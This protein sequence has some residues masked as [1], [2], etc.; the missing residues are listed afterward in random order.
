MQKHKKEDIS[1][2]SQTSYI[3][4]FLFEWDTLSG[5]IALKRIVHL[6]KQC[7]ILEA[8]EWNGHNCDMWLTVPEKASRP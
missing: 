7:T 4:N 8:G 1:S 6:N 3:C 2:I 5:T